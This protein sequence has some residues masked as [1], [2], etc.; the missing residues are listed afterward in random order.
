ADATG[1]GY[2]EPCTEDADCASGYCLDTEAG[3]LCSTECSD[4]AECGT[5]W[6]C[7]PPNYGSADSICF[8][9]TN[10]ICAT[11]CTSDSDCSVYGSLCVEI[12]GRSVCSRSCDQRACPSDYNCTETDS[13]DGT[14]SFQCLP[15]AGTCGDCT[16]SDGDG[17]GVGADCSQIDCDDTDSDVNPDASERC[18]GADD[19]CD[20][21]VDEGCGCDFDGETDGVCATA[22]VDGDGDCAQPSDY[23]ADEVSCDGLDNDCDG[24]VDEGCDCD[25]N[26]SSEGVCAN[27]TIGSDGNCAQPTDYESDETSCGDTLDNDCDGVVDEG[28]P[29]DY[30]GNSDG[31]CGTATIDDTGNCAAPTTYESDEST[32]GDGLDNDCD[33]AEDEG[34]ACDYNNESDGVCG[35]ATRDSSGACQEPTE[36]EADETACD[37]AD[38]DCDGQVDEGCTC[39]DG[40]TQ[41]CYSGPSGTAGEGLCQQG[42]QTCSGGT[43]GSCDNEVLPTTETCGNN[44]DEDCDGLVDEGCPCDYNGTSTGVCSGGTLDGSGT[45]TAPADYESPESSCDGKDNN[46]DGTVDEGCCDNVDAASTVQST[47]ACLTNGT[48]AQSAIVV[49]LVDT[50]GNPVTGSTVTMSTS[51]G[52]LTGVNSNGNTYYAILTPPA[53]SG[54]TGT[55]V[56]VEATDACSG[57]TV[58]LTSVNVAFADP[59]NGTAGGAGGCQADGNVR[60]QVVQAEDGTPIQGA[61]VMVG[62]QENTSAYE[63]TFGSA[64]SGSNTGT[65]DAQG[66]I[67]FNDFGTV[68]DTPV[69]VTAAAS[70]RAYKSMMGA[71]AAD[72]ILP[73]E[74]INPNIDTGTYSGRFTGIDNG[75]DVDAG[76]MLGDVDSNSLL[77]F[78]LDKL[79]ADDECYQSGSSLVDDSLLPGNTYIPAQTL[80]V[81]GFPVGINEKT[82]TSPKLEYGSRKLVGLAGETTTNAATSGDF[83]SILQELDLQKIGVRTENVSTASTTGYDIPMDTDL[84][85]NISCEHSNFPTGSD[86][87]CLTNGDWDS[88]ND[89][90]T[91]LGAGRLF[92]MGLGVISTAT[93]NNASYTISDVTTVADSGDFAGIEYFGASAALY[94][95]SGNAPSPD[96]ANGATIIARRSANQFDGTGGTLVYDDY[97]PL[98]T[99]TRQQRN[100]AAS[101]VSS[102]SYPSPH[103]TRTLFQHNITE[104]YDACGTDDA[105]RTITETYWTVY[106]PASM[107]S[108]DLPIPPAGWPRQTNGIY[109]G[110]INPNNTTD[111][112]TVTWLHTT[113]HEAPNASTFDYDTL[114]FNTLR[115]AVTHVTLNSQEL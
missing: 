77:N 82:Y 92:L 39:T 61:N 74:A 71:D 13:V 40:D 10:D 49:E 86:L 20:G 48:S 79:L 100:F 112:D 2:M 105:E 88:L 45:C 35:T 91:P 55:S 6:V 50:A 90:S 85:P 52:S 108:W 34:C 11:D 38:N 5:E 29:C 89:A 36:Y 81:F 78:N 67:E 53:T 7:D 21:V 101:A 32:C 8:P 27:S 28:C 96:L 62:D 58:Q 25:F 51:A 37:G 110:M 63:S 43:W 87:F 104:T 22:T 18:N 95:D 56:S 68:L 70:G 93:T 102:G 103:Y 99:L 65:T 59:I 66:Y 111:D 31:V 33:G 42:T 19:N 60:V 3:L 69:T 94:L 83:V 47:S 64:G 109:S 12:D 106:A 84:S 76:L 114:R 44:T 72:F 30:D 17:F 4:D 98:R 80:R 15:G 26:G 113:L 9:P 16:D 23:E 57:S 97:L 75:G 46:C 41:N 73:L 1:A 115:E 54:V 14:T 107:N 24:V